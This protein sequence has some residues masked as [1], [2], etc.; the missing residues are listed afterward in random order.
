MVMTIRDD[1]LTSRKARPED[2]ARLT[3]CEEDA[4]RLTHAE[5]DQVAAAG[6]KPGV[7]P[8]IGSAW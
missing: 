8:G 7:S 2:G 4:V 3:V 6:S 5:L 1:D